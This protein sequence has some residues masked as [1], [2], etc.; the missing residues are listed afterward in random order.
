M[1]NDTIKKR[2]FRGNLDLFPQLNEIYELELAFEESE[3]MSD[4]DLLTR[5]AYF[6]RVNERYTNHFRICAGD[7]LLIPDEKSLS[8]RHFF[9]RNQFRTGYGTHG[10]FPYRGK[11]HPQ[12][13]KGLLNT[14]ELIPGETVLDPMMGSGTVLVEA[15]LM[16]IHSIG[17]DASPF[18]RFMAQAKAIG[19]YV[20]IEPL[21]LAVGRS[22]ELLNHF[23]R[24]CSS[25][26]ARLASYGTMYKSTN[27]Q[28]LPPQ[29]FVP[30]TYQYLLL[31]FLDSAG[32][33]Q[34]SSRRTPEQQFHQV[35]ER[36]LFVTEKVQKVMRE[37][38]IVPGKVTPVEGD[39]RSLSLEDA[40]VDGILFSPPYSFA[41][42]YL[43]NDSFHLEYLGVNTTVLRKNMIGLRGRTLRDKFEHYQ[44]DMRV[45]LEECVRVLRVGRCCTIII[46]TNR[47]QLGKLLNLPP[48]D[49]TGL[50]DLVIDIAQALGLKLER[51]I[52][53]QILGI[54]NTMRNEEILIFR[55]ANSARLG[56]AETTFLN[57]TTYGLR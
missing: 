38:E 24:M 29:W 2:L 1:I 12:M 19:F 20:P 48:E 43:E 37:L 41:I 18:C 10:L 34:R 45:V 44:V 25:A 49:V 11:F 33:A 50:D 7:A 9:A 47:N 27:D 54:S 31:A 22:S 13:V 51:Q 56:S 3:V 26:H 14:M 21:R 6:A 5:G 42:D 39:A 30:E 4:E 36:Y 8:R 55:K 53:R 17:I 32:Y 52:T 57:P 23:K 46:G 15:S 35:L 40:S 16:G 28:S